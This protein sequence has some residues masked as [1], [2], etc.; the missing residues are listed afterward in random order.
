MPAAGALATLDPIA[1]IDRIAAGEYLSH[2]AHKLGVAPQSLHQKLRDHPDYKPA[3][4]TRHQLRLDTAEESLATAPDLARAREQFRAA[5]WRAEREC[6]A[7]WGPSNEI[8]G[9]DGGPLTVEVV[10]FTEGRTIDA[11]QQLPSGSSAPLL[12]DPSKAK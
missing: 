11:E 1:V 12:A 10:R 2:I 5:A 7:I 8:T 9:K 4:Q 3:M 6:K